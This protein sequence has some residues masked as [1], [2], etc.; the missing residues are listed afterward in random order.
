MQL[1][2]SAL[3]QVMNVATVGLLI[4]KKKESVYLNYR[5]IQYKLAL[6]VEKMRVY[7]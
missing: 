7:I 3:N 2:Q 6:P 4:E 1:W 5:Y